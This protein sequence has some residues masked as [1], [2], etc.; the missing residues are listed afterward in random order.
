MRDKHSKDAVRKYMKGVSERERREVAEAFLD[1]TE[2]A[3]PEDF[4]RVPR[5]VVLWSR[6]LSAALVGYYVYAYGGIFRA[7]HLGT[8]L[9]LLTM[10]VIAWFPNKLAWLSTTWFDPPPSTRRIFPWGV[11]VLSWIV[12]LSLLFIRL[13]DL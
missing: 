4:P 9:E 6:F 12:L 11:F 10:V 8:L 13:G 1:S 7:R 3:N 5:R 2:R